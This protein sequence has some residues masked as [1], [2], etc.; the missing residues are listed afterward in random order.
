M[1]RHC[2]V[3]GI[4]V[5]SAVRAEEP[6]PNGVAEVWLQRPPHNYFDLASL[7]Q[8]AD[9]LET[10]AEKPD[11]RAVVLSAQGRSFCAGFDFSR[12]RDR[13]TPDAVY[14]IARRILLQPLPLVAAVEGPA[15]GGGLGLALAADFRVFSPSTTVAAN[16]AQLGFHHG[17]ALSVTLPRAA[18]HQRALELLLTGRRIHGDEAHAIGICDR[19]VQAG[20]T[21]GAAHE[22][23]DAIASSGPLAV[24]SVRE[25]MRRDVAGAIDEALK[26]EA[27]EQTRLGGTRDFREGIRASAE[28]RTPQFTGE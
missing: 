19:L 14:A 8:L 22:L 7:T 23:A 21:L 1:E 15:I 4:E 12:K 20:D 24:R 5:A 10:L 18:G 26:R 27:A 16:F 3:S 13:S 17:F 11:C 2:R 9:A 28:R 6:Q 25:T